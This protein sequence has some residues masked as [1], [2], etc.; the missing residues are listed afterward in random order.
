[1]TRKDY[2]LSN[3]FH[4]KA[5]TIRVADGEIISKGRVKRLHNQLCGSPDCTCSGELGTRGHQEIDL[6]P[7]QDGTYTARINQD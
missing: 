1:M 6:I 5:V 2:T 4:K 3:D 7:N